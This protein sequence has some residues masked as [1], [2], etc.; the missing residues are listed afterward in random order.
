MAPSGLQRKRLCKTSIVLWYA[1]L[2]TSRVEIIG[3]GLAGSEAALQLAERGVAVTLYEMRPKRNTPVHSSDYCGELVCSNSL[4]SKKPESA[5]GMIKHELSVLGSHLLSIAKRHEVKAGGALAVDRDAFAKEITSR[6]KNHP[7]I[8]LVRS[9]IK[10]IEAKGDAL[11]V[12]TGPLTSDAL[13]QSISALTGSENLSFFD[14]AAPIVTTESINTSIVFSMSR[15][16]EGLGDYLNAPFTKEEYERFIHEL[17]SAERVIKKEFETKDLF[18]ACQP[19]EEIA[20]KGIDAPR[21]G[22]MKPVGL[23]DPR[24]GK[25]PWAVVQLRSENEH[26]SCYNLVGFQTNLTFGEQ[27]RVFRLIP[28]LE[29]ADFTRHG[30]MHRNTFIDAPHILDQHFMLKGYDVCPLYFAGQIAGTEGYCEAIMS[31]LYVALSVYARL[32]GKTF[33]PLPSATASGALFDYATNPHTSN[34]QPMHVNFGILPPLENHIRQ[35]AFRYAAYAKRGSE[36][37]VEYSH[38]LQSEGIIGDTH[39]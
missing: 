14:A 20:R 12:A 6:I 25:R 28:G 5:A 11:I 39:E 29:K 37:L 7:N 3:A 15:Y 22:A 4:K 32:E 8:K 13:S 31:G 10:T 2:M 30:V 9:E 26:A 23:I 17:V 19:I 24:T 1:L 36:S 34:Y 18:Q 33:S 21:Y 35:K 38:V 16:E 27:D